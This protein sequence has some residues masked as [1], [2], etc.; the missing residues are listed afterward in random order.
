MNFKKRSGLKRIAQRLPKPIISLAECGG[1]LYCATVDG[2][3]YLKKNRWHKL[4]IEVKQ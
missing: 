2:I 1:T 4:K 3:F